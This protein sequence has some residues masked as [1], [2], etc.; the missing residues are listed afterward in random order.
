MTK[1]KTY[2][3]TIFLPILVGGL[4]GLIISNYMDYDLIN[5]PSLAPPSTIFPI[6]WT[7][8]YI[9]MGT[10]YGILQSNYL[11]TN[12]IKL[13]YYLQLLVNALWPII[14]F[15]LKWQLL[16]FIVI[17][18]LIGLVIIMLIN[19]YKQ[20]EVAGL[21]QIPYLLWI[22]FASYLNLSIYLSNN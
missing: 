14:F 11:I 6:M 16:A 4:V 2:F 5:K 15:V 18:L 1:L 22:V 12:K 8:I 19:F 13:I 9:L 17:L 3:K 20:N 21:L 7:I 10:S